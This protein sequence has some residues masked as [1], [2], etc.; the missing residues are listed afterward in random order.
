MQRRNR[1]EISDRRARDVGGRAP[2]RSAELPC[3]VELRGR[4]IHASGARVDRSTGDMALIAKAPSDSATSDE[5][6]SSTHARIA[7]SSKPLY[8]RAVARMNTRFGSLF[9]QSP[10]RLSSSLDGSIPEMS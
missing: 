8:M 7:S 10:L 5:L 3:K 1:L 9:V 6:L 2:P 4:K